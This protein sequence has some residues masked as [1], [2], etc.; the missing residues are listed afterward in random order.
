MSFSIS[1]FKVYLPRK[2]L[3]ME[4]CTKTV[5]VLEL[6][7]QACP[8]TCIIASFP[9]GIHPSIHAAVE[10]ADIFKAHLFETPRC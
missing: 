5:T 3:V 2:T 4:Y 1:N 8:L 7:L 6:V 10:V 9:V